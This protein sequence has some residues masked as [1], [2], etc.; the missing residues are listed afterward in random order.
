MGSHTPHG[1]RWLSYF[2]GAGVGY[3]A[4]EVALLQKYGLFLGH[5]NYALSIVLAALLLATG[6]GSLLSGPS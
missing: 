2:A 3:L 6:V 1:A 5:P 4:I